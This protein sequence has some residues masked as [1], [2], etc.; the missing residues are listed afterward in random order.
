MA[1]VRDYEVNAK[2]HQQMGIP[3]GRTEMFAR[4]RGSNLRGL[5]RC[6]EGVLDEEGGGDGGEWA[7]SVE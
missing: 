1:Y 7:N 4:R 2:L 3:E 5:R 6:D